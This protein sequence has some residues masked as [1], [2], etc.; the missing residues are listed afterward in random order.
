MIRVFSIS[1][2]V[3]N[4]NPWGGSSIGLSF[5]EER[6]A[7]LGKL[8]TEVLDPIS[9]S[10]AIWF[11]YNTFSVV[12]NQLNNIFSLDDAISYIL[13]FLVSNRRIPEKEYADLALT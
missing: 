3:R 6:S 9:M 5:Q 11:K 8:F 10:R 7:K 4:S 2:Q 12:L 13:Y 1:G